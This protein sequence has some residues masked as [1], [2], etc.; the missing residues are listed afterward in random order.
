MPQCSHRSLLVALA[1]GLIAGAAFAQSS[2]SA[3]PGV[4]E[5]NLKRLQEM[6]DTI[7]ADSLAP[8]SRLTPLG[9]RVDWQTRVNRSPG[10]ILVNAFVAGDAIYT[11]D[12]NNLV[13]RVS[14][15]RGE[16]IWQTPVGASSDELLDV[17]RVATSDRN[18]VMVVGR[19][20]V[21]LIDFQSGVNEARE[22]VT[23]TL[24]TPAAI[25]GPYLIYGSRGGQITWHQWEV[26]YPW[27]GNSLPGSV[28]AEPLVVD[29]M[30]FAVG[31]TGRILALDANSTR[32]RWEKQ[33][34]TGIDAR[35]AYADELL[36]VAG[37]DQY[38][39]ALDARDGST[40]W[41]YF[42]ESQL[43]TPPTVVGNAVYQWVPTE[44][45]VKC[46]LRPQD[47]IDGEVSWRQPEATG[48]IIATHQNRLL[49][50]DPFARV[51]KAVDIT[52][53]T[54]IDSISLPRVRAISTDGFD[55]TALNFL[56][57]DGTVMRAVA[58]N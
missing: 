28:T 58:Q 49:L 53:G 13:S 30:V 17:Y 32:L 54:V 10:S 6:R 39:W 23:P 42:T 38:L 8:P 11:H 9:Y 7:D 5:G 47:R 34:V 56:S 35:P 4:T 26:G 25:R 21:H 12:A 48:A 2:G 14:L 51:L 15:D 29:D 44:G 37:R 57:E 24:N 19:L 18:Q 31:S 41:R 55:G 43:I 27:R 16:V 1:V 33:L 45:L 22:R 52:T 3:S 46:V 20:A 36:L 50:W 40:V